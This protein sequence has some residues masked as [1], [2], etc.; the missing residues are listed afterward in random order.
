M[1]HLTLAHGPH[2]SPAASPAIVEEPRAR[3]ES[4][5]ASEESRA[6]VACVTVE[7]GHAEGTRLRRRRTGA[8]D[9][10]AAGSLTLFSTA[11][12]IQTVPTRR[13][14]DAS[15]SRH[16]SRLL[17]HFCWWVQN[18]SRA[19]PGERGGGPPRAAPDESGDGGPHLVPKWPEPR[20]LVQA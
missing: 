7:R 3:T 16:P 18:G 8:P 4:R 20:R 17:P 10:C 12:Q 19:A 14:P 9:H 2:P 5:C 11:P 15:S 13:R 6:S 1:Q